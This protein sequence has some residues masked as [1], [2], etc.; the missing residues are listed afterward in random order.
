MKD[1]SYRLKTDLLAIRHWTESATREGIRIPTGATVT[2]LEAPVIG[3]PLVEVDWN[4]ES[5]LMFA[6][7][8]ALHAEMIPEKP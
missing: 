5:L 7:D 1:T 3:E 8:I 4:G 2:V 6:D